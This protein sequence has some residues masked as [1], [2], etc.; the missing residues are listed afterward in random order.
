MSGVDHQAL[1]F[2][3]FRDRTTV[4]LTDRLLSVFR[5]LDG[6]IKQNL[7]KNG[8]VIEEVTYVLEGC[9]LHFITC[10]PLWQL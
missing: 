10:W 2:A 1:C 8:G 4:V 3:L 6:Y 5:F 9:T 7:W